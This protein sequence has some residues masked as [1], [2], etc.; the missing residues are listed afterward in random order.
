VTQEFFDGQ[1][2]A[3]SLKKQGGT[4]MPTEYVTTARLIDAGLCFASP[5]DV[6]NHL[7]VESLPLIAVE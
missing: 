6:I 3:A 7:A 5:K 1:Q 2:I 4:A